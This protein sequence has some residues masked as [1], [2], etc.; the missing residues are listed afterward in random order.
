M[1]L[2]KK[3][4]DIIR[5]YTPSELKGKYLNISTTLGYFRPVSANWSCICGYVYYKGVP[6]LVVTRFGEII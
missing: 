4:I 1:N 6:V 3:Q 2:T 5:R